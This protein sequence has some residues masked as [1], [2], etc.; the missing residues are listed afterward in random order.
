MVPAAKTDFQLCIRNTATSFDK[1]VVARPAFKEGI[2]P[3][4]G[5]NDLS[6]APVSR[7]PDLGAYTSSGVDP[8]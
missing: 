5:G 2:E 7:S 3:I 1:N 4:A 6:L 8:W